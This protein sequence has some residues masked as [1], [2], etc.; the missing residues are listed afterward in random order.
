MQIVICA[1]SFIFCTQTVGA[2]SMRQGSI[3]SYRLVITFISATCIPHYFKVLL[4]ANVSHT[5]SKYFFCELYSTLTP[6]YFVC[7]TLSH[8]NSKY[9]VCKLSHTNS[10]YFV[11]K[12]SIPH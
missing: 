2:V 10:K 3:S 11:C 8:T 5:N 1:D 6:K 9:F 4:L 12:L 7:K